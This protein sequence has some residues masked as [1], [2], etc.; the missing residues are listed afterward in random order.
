MSLWSF[1]PQLT[2]LGFSKNRKKTLQ[3]LQPFSNLIVAT[4]VVLA[5]ELTIKWNSLRGVDTLSSAGQTIPFLI[6][7]GAL[8][9]VF[10]VYVKPMILRRFGQDESAVSTKSETEPDPT[11]AWDMPVL[12]APMRRRMDDDDKEE[13]EEEGEGEREREGEGDRPP[14]P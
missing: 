12:Q 4:I 11:G 14:S 3:Q 7:V 6:G 1:G 8:V 5:T 2:H 9:H 10:Y 13:E